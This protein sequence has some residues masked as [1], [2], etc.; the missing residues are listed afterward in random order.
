MTR[1]GRALLLGAGLGCLLYAQTPGATA[2]GPADKRAGAYYNFA[3]GRL[4]T[5]LA[6]SSGSSREYVSKAIQFYQEALKLDPS[7]K[8]VLDELTDLYIQTNRLRDAATQA[9]DMLKQNPDNLDARRMLGRV[10]VRQLGD[11]QQ[12]KI[13]ENLLR[14]AMEQFQKVTEKDP[15]DADSWVM[16]GRLYRVSANSVEAEKALNNA[17]KAEPDNEDALT[18]LAQLYLTVGDVNKAVEKLKSATDKR[19]NERTLVVLATAYEQMRDFKN[20]ADALKRALELSPDDGR[21]QRN[22]AQDLFASGQYD[23]ALKIYQQLSMEDARNAMLWVRIS[24]IYRAKRD[25]PKAQ[26]ALG[27]AKAIEPDNLTVRDAEI[28]LLEAQ[29]KTEQAIASLK[30]LLEETARKTYSAE[31]SANR[32]LLLEK[33]GILYVKA[34]QYQPAIDAFRQITPLDAD[35]APRVAVQIV[36][37]YQS[38]KDYDNALKEADAA[39]KKFPN[40]KMVVMAHASVLADRGKADEAASEVRGLLKAGPDFDTQLALARILDKGKR[41]SEQAK[42]LDQAEALAKSEDQKVQVLFTRGAMH[43]RM[44]NYDAAETEFRQVLKLD[45][46]NAGA[47]N[48]LGYMLAFRNLRLDEAQKFVAKALELDPDNPAYLDS[49]GWVYYQQGKL[50]EAEAP[51]L[52]ANERM[53]DDP[54]VHDHLGDLYL[55]MGKTKEAIAEWQTSLRR[56]QAGAPADN[57]PDD[58]GKIT[59][60]LESARVRLAKETGQK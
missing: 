22:L 30:G 44:K 31:E 1:F 17:L 20:A 35:G 41:F 59:K 14:R 15:T 53:G 32:A 57:D 24:E 3:M 5:E 33:L 34:G 21:L 4:Y 10:Y 29:G 28:S 55:K 49:L 43:E 42:V 36:E 16:L 40:E 8:V 11:P 56:Y 19:P 45:P 47:L 52:R 46:D 6:G 50:T 38:A 25:F 60:K 2:N 51:L 26:E 39:K 7:S 12:G 18:Q 27:R 58:V 13:D 9:E 37:T 54:T 23:E 48:Y